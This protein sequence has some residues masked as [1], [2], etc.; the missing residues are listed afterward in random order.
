MVSKMVKLET[1]EK[2]K[3]FVALITPYPYEIDICSG[4]FL[5]D[6]R[7]IQGIFSL[8]TSKPVQVVIH[9]DDCGALLDELDA[10]AYKEQP[11][12]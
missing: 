1:V 12:I 6:A 4:R 2:V 3:R 9:A 5:V 11:E 10:F 8:D 7:S